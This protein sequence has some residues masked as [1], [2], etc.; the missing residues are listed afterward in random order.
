MGWLKS[1]WKM[2]ER[3]ET[4]WATFQEVCYEGDYQVCYGVEGSVSLR[5]KRCEE[6][7]KDE[8]T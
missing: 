8:G 3:V 1:E 2:N 6:I 4:I 7:H 5:Q